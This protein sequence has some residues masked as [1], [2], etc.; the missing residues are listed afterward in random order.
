MKAV[1]DTNVFVSGVFWK[2]PPRVILEAWKEKKFHWVVSAPVLDEYQRVLNDLGARY[3]HVEYARILELVAVHA[4][5]VP[6]I[7]FAK[8]ICKDKDDDV[9]L[10]PAISAGDQYIVSGDKLLLEVD[11][12]RGLQIMKPRA[13]LKVLQS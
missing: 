5:I 7:H 11:G 3:P 8:P 12:F 1:I 2:G 6:T 10:A 13:F 9:F 4:E